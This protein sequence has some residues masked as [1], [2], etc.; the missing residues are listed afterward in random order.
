MC[1][2]VALFF[3]PLLLQQMQSLQLIVL[4]LL[5]TQ[6]IDNLLLLLFNFSQVFTCWAQKAHTGLQLLLLL[7]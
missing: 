6:E 5:F 4:S 3:E 1:E 2:A 7:L